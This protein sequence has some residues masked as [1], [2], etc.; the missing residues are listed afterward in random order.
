MTRPVE[1][2]TGS[3]KPVTEGAPAPKPGHGDHLKPKSAAESEFQTQ[4]TPGAVRGAPVKLGSKEYDAD[5]WDTPMMRTLKRAITGW[6]VPAA[7]G[8]LTLS[9]VLKADDPRLVPT[10]QRPG[11]EAWRV[12]L[13]SLV[14]SAGAV[15]SKPTAY[16]LAGPM[17]VG[18]IA[19]SN[20]LYAEGALP[21][22]VVKADAD[23]LHGL[24]PE[25]SE[26]L[27]L[28]DGRANDVVHEESSG[29]A[30]GAFFQALTE[31]R[32]VVHNTMLGSSAHLE[33]LD[34]AKKAGFKN[35][36]IAMVAPLEVARARAGAGGAVVPEPSFTQS[37]RDFAKNFDGVVKGADDLVL[38]MNLGTRLEVIAQGKAGELTVKNK[39]A[40]DQFRAMQNL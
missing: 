5:L 22:A 6:A 17:G 15:Q 34:E 9:P 26:L 14:V 36:V 24:V 35:V 33:R 39:A 12:S 40:Y 25:Q 27:A 16:Y 30:R 23:Y 31:K 1:S 11:R 10:D 3:G 29:I 13:Q 32:D 8:G 19:I 38:V 4:F 18:K 28:G 20:R 2:K 7:G 21:A 37:H